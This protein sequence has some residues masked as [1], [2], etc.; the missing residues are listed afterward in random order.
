M[1][2]TEASK[3]EQAAAPCCR[4]G[5][6]VGFVLAAVTLTVVSVLGATGLARWLRP[7]TVEPTPDNS[8]AP[9]LFRGWEAPA[10]VFLLSA[11]MHGYMLPCGCSEPQLG[12]LERRFNFLEELRAKGWP[13]LALDLGDIPQKQ[14]PVNLP[15][16]QG[17]IKYRYSMKALQKMG[18]A[19]VSFGEYE[20][21]LQLCDVLA[22]WALQYPTPPFVSG[23][24]SEPDF[25]E[26]V[27]PWQQ[28]KA[29]GGK[30]SVGVTAIVG[31]TVLA[32][33]KDP[34]VKFAS[35]EKILPGILTEMKAKKVDLRVV[36]YHGSM[37]LPPRGFKDPEAIAL[38]KAFPELDLILCLSESDEPAGDPTVVKH[39]DDRKTMVVSLGH[40]SKYVGV[41]GV[42]AT[43]NEP[44]PYELRYQLVQLSPA[45]KTPKE[46]VKDHPIIDLTE[47]YTRELKRDNYLE[48]VPQS[49]HPNQVAVQGVVP[50]YEGSEVCRKCHKSAFKVWNNS[51]HSK[52][53]LTLVN[54]TQ[55]SLRQYDPE[56]IVC[57]TV[58]FGNQSGF[59]TA[60]KTPDLKNVGCESCHGPASEHVKNKNNAAWYPLLNPW[61]APEK[62]TPE[63]KTKRLLRIDR[64]CQTCHDID[65]DVTWTH[66]GLSRKWPLIAHPTPPDE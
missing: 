46:K 2:P 40:K 21:A 47:E 1:L 25:K 16:R 39:A 51:K 49:R 66:G 20:A 58:G 19:A 37:Q 27:R 53:Y 14:G 41:V 50:T 45:Y 36:L 6:G 17:M 32:Q 10:M 42:F 38:A 13:V 9:V 65:N 11:Q 63:D 57:H 28:V 62:E 43:G 12:G 24:L 56:C 55:P 30:V 34:A 59:V 61:K 4:V 5:R 35:T 60:D 48:K 8:P 7:A 18:Y 23:N 22:E 52:A 44:M 26:W 29:E 33:I 31:P 3:D 15:N 64:M 54:A